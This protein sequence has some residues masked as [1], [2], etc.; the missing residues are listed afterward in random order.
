MG[1]KEEKLNIRQ[2]YITQRKGLTTVQI[3]TNSREIG[4]Q[5][6]KHFDFQ[7]KRIS[8]FLSIPQQHEVDTTHITKKLAN[9]NEIFV[10]VSDFNSHTM[11][12]WKLLPEDQLEANRYGIPEPKLRVHEANPKSIDVVIVP[13]LI[14]D[15]NGHRLGYGK[16]FYDRFLSECRADVLKIGLNYFEP[17]SQIP[18]ED[19]D[20]PL[21]FL[22]TPTTCHAFKQ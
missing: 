18:A 19:T 21:D 3:H 20:I 15:V 1:L 12:H 16:G 11:Q 6:F 2:V 8:C 9:H 4:E 7:G 22:I 10:P 14:C 5:L 17:I 13:L